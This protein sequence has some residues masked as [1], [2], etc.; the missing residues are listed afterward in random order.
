MP[1]IGI[2]TELDALR[3]GGEAPSGSNDDAESGLAS[4]SSRHSRRSRQSQIKSGEN[5][6]I[7][8]V[9]EQVRNFIRPAE[10]QTG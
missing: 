7:L 8:N 2:D 6:L 9:Y 5:V 3:G 10:R 4:T 1:A